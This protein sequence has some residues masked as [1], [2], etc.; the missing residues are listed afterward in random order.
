[1]LL[2]GGGLAWGLAAASR[3]LPAGDPDAR[4]WQ[5]VPVVPG[6]D[7]F[8]MAVSPSQPTT[9]Y[10]ATSRGLY[11]SSDG[12]RA[13]THVLVRAAGGATDDVEDEASTMPAASVTLMPDHPE[14]VFAALGPRLWRSEDDG[15]TWQALP[16]VG[17]GA[18]MIRHLRIMPGDPDHLYA[19]T[20]TGVFRVLVSAT[21]P[22]LSTWP[23]GDVHTA[24]SLAHE[25]GICDV[26]QA[27]IRYAEVRPQK[28]HRWRTAAA[29]R[30]WV[31]RFTLTLNRNTDRTI[32]SAASG[33][34]TT[35]AVGPDDRSLSVNYGFT[36]DL[37]NLVWNPDQTSIDARS[38]LMVQLR[39]DILDEV[40]RLYFER[41]RLQVEYAMIPVK[42]PSLRAERSLRI[43]EL[44]AQLDALTGGYFSKKVLES[45]VRES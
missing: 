18:P 14:I 41:R 44:T 1:V 31:P 22:G 36:W 35:F 12:G 34:K 28:I 13:W 25:P 6:A 26:Q 24:A 11:R 2:I 3:T 4:R 37:A 7:V 33:G 8:E 43:E 38:R 32:S 17:L 39:N 16:P 10:A 42:E 27:A 29:W 45:G 21:S 15:R 9:V 20:A 5:A 19:T 40:T 30:A 23:L